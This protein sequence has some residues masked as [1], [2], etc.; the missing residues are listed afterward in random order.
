MIHTII[1]EERRKAPR[2]LAIAINNDL[3]TPNGLDAKGMPK[4]I[5]TPR[6]AQLHSMAKEIP[7][8]WGIKREGEF[9]PGYFGT[10]DDAKA[11][12]AD[13]ENE[14]LEGIDKGDLTVA[15]MSGVQSDQIVYAA[16]WDG[17]SPWI[18]VHKGNV[19]DLKMA[20]LGWP[21]VTQEEWEV[22]NPQGKP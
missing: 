13:P 4:H 20:Y 22:V 7:E 19:A 11:A 8:K 2:E 21:M 15:Y 12:L 3:R 6:P 9:L 16:E 17:I 14:M 5:V 18:V 10:K 1:A